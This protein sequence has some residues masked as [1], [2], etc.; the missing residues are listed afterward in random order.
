MIEKNN[1]VTMYNSFTK[2]EVTKGRL[3]ANK[4]EESGISNFISQMLA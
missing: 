4:T 3:V 1:I 2:E